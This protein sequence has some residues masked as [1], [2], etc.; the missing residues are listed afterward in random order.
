[1]EHL[2]HDWLEKT[3]MN[4]DVPPMKNADFR[5]SHVSF[6]GVHH[7]EQIRVTI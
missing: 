4:E 7:G 3:T 1:M 5:A 2:G 6:R